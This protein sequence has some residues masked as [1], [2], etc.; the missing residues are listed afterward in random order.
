MGSEKKPDQEE[1]EQ[2]Q[3]SEVKA[4][5]ETEKVDESAEASVE[6][7]LEAEKKRADENWEKVLLAKAELENVRRRTQNDITKAHQ[8]AIE[9]IA[10]E[11]ILVVDSFEIGLE[12]ARKV[13]GDTTS[14]KE[15]ME[16]TYKQL[17]TTLTK[18][19][20]AQINPEGEA[21]DPE[22]HQAMSM[23][24]SDEHEANSVMQV[25]QKGFSLN[26]RLLRPAMVIVSQAP[27]KE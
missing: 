20:I 25:F 1:L 19:G 14:I 8:F 4:T 16:L 15:G 5:S 12:A 13:D 9:K 6:I 11:L 27:A 7:K 26:G 17:M 24:P 10:K 2:T 21:F 18:S 23:L 22:L 3:E